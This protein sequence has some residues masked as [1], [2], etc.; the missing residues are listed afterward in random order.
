MKTDSILKY[1][2]VT[3]GTNVMLPLLDVDRSKGDS[4]NIIGN[5][6]FYICK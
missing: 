1:P 4:K 6:L 3:I 5:K 2:V